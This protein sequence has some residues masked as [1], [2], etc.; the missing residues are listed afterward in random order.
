VN[1]RLVQ[2]ENASIDQIGRNCKGSQTINTFKKS[3]NDCYKIENWKNNSHRQGSNSE[4]SE[5]HDKDKYVN[6]NRKI[7]NLKLNFLPC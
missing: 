2:K 1:C 3:N 7:F 6:N 4:V 5:N